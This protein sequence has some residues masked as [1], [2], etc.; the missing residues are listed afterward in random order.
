MILLN[1]SH[2]LTADQQSQA[3]AMTGQAVDRKIEVFTQFDEQQPFE[4]QLDA[5]LDEVDL[6]P[7]AWQTEALLVVLPA[8]NFIAAMVLAGLHGRM[9]YF[10]PVLRLRPA[11]GS[12]PR[13]FEAAEILDLQALRDR[14]RKQRSSGA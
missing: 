13:R 10:P 8:L 4:P 9:G 11:P 3:E 2:P 5:L 12:L 14:E 7:E 1:F 6:S